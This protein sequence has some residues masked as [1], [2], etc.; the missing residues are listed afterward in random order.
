VAAGSAVEVLPGGLGYL[1]G[2]VLAVYVHG[3][4]EE[5]RVL[6][7]LFGERPPRTLE[8]VFDGL[9]DAIEEHL[10]VSFLLR[11]AGIA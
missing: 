5:P 10:D 1:K 11:E 4:L 6:Q 2:S 7:A 3:L 9:A 8:Q